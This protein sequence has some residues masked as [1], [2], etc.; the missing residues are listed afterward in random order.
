ML[1]TTEAVIIYTINHHHHHHH[2]HHPCSRYII[3]LRMNTH[4][5]RVSINPPFHVTVIIAIKTRREHRLLLP[6]TQQRKHTLGLRRVRSEQQLRKEEEE[7]FVVK[8][9]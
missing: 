6:G 4:I 9:S 8:R 7:E 2:H 1:A 5:L 3:V